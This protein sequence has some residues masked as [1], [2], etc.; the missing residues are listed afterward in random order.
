LIVEAA[1]DCAHLRLG[2][3][4]RHGRSKSSNDEPEFSAAHALA[5]RVRLP[6]VRVEPR[7]LEIR[8]EDADDRVR[9]AIEHK[10]R[11]ERIARATET[12]LPQA[13]TDQDQPLPLLHFFVGEAASQHGLDA[14]QRKQVGRNA[15]GADLLRPVRGH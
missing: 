13:M 2:L 1:G 14:E 6:H 11:A 5:A 8:R 12:C 9:N 3:V 7:D 4:E 10:A 15:S